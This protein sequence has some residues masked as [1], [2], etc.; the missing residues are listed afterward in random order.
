LQNKCPAEAVRQLPFTF[1]INKSDSTVDMLFSASFPFKHYLITV[2][3]HPLSCLSTVA[4]K[5]TQLN[6]HF[7]N[8]ITFFREMKK[9]EV[10]GKQKASLTKAKCLTGE[11][12]P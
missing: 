9:R 6:T 8:Y 1:A 5:K 11:L 4:R 12:R 10:S 2:K 3:T 7:G